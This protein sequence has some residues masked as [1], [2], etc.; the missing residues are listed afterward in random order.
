MNLTNLEY[1]ESAIQ[2]FDFDLFSKSIV[3]D[4]TPSFQ[5]LLIFRKSEYS[6][7]HPK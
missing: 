5:C 6:L 7:Q 3:L 4:V 2:L 1:A